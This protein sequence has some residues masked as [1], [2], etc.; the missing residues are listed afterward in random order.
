MA[1]S[2]YH[3]YQ[4]KISSLQNE[5]TEVCVCDQSGADV[6]CITETWCRDA[7]PDA[8]VNLVPYTIL[9]NDRQNRVGG[10]VIAYVRNTLTLKHWSDLEDEDF[11]TLWFTIRPRR[12]PRQFT[13]I[14]FGIVYHPPSDDDQ[15]LAKHIMSDYYRTPSI[16]PPLGQSDH[17]I[18]LCQPTGVTMKNK[19][20]ITVKEVRISDPTYRAMFGEA[21]RNTNWTPIYHLETT[22]EQYEFFVSKIH[23]LLDAYLPIKT[24]KTRSN[25]RPWITDSFKMLVS[26]KQ[27]AWH[28]KRFGLYKYLKN[29]VNRESKSLQR[30]FYEQKITEV[31]SGQPKQLWNVINQVTGERKSTDRLQGLCNN[32]CDG[33]QLEFVEKIGLSL[34][35]V[36]DDLTPLTSDDLIK[37]DCEVPSDLIIFVEAVERSLLSLKVSKAVG[38][39]RIP[40]W[41]LRD[42]AGILGRPIACIFNSSI[43]LGSLPQMWRSAD[44]IPLPKVANPIQIEKDLRPISLPLS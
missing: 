9:R 15:A 35:S 8:P 37:V 10:G 22:E 25:D 18:I 19:P 11:E 14:T 38:P 42:Y 6:V 5:R 1:F 20:C 29:K 43:R 34:Q 33:N 16:E 30:R 26:K 21:L 40:N 36:S 3:K 2:Y 44:V 24:I 13:C 39:D 7:I 28:E 17:N 41:V 31:T 23:S 4:C 27:R 12:L 32:L